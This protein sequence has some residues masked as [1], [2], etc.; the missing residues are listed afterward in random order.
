EHIEY[1]NADGTGAISI[2]QSYTWQGTTNM[3]L[4][5]TRTHPASLVSQN[6]SGSP[7]TTRA[8]YDAFGRVLWTMDEDGFINSFSYDSL[9]GAVTQKIVDVNTALVTPPPGW[10]TPPGGGLHLV[11]AIVVD[12]LGR[13]TKATDP[14]GQVSYTVYKDVDHELRHYAAWNAATLSPTGP[15]LVTR[16]DRP[17][18]YTETVT[19]SATPAV[20]SGEPT[21]AEPVSNLQ[22]LSRTYLDGGDRAT[23]SDSYFDFAAG[24]FAYSTLP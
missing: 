14:L 12:S 1:R 6:G 7:T 24:G 13:A 23:H 18:S 8:R 21:G 20:L 9:T 16:E 22:S 5:A 11:T 15:T 19:M 17:G 3:V 10:A 4:E 2:F